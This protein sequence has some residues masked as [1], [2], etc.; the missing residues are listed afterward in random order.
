MLPV[1]A[2]PMLLRRDSVLVSYRMLHSYST[3]VWMD[4]VGF[5][6]LANAAAAPY[7]Y[8]CNIS[9]GHLT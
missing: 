1:S 3:A 4:R 8:H 5:R 2:T 7:N 6:S 9:M